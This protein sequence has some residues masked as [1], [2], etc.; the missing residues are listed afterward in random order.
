MKNYKFNCLF[1]FLLFFTFIYCSS[2][3][4]QYSYLVDA[5]AKIKDRALELN[6][7]T[8]TSGGSIYGAYLQNGSSISLTYPFE[9]GNDYKII[10]Y[11]DE[12]VQDLDLYLLTID[13]D[14][15]TKDVTTDNTPELDYTPPY[16]GS[17]TIKIL[18]YQSSA[19]SF[20]LIAILVREYDY[21]NKKELFRQAAYGISL[22]SG[23]LNEADLIFTSGF[24]LFGSY[25][26]SS[27]SD[28]FDNFSVETSGDY[29]YFASCSD[30]GEDTDVII[31]DKNSGE[32][33][34]KDQTTNK[35]AATSCSLSSYK[36]Y[37]LEY[38]N[39]RSDGGA[40]V[41]SAIMK[42]Q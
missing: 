31:H 32:I 42:S 12:D 38:K 19:P 26:S 15:I 8:F 28:F 5:L 37:K 4:A 25:L 36:T 13:G 33:I 11:A 16:S 20:C 23:V 9:Y 6:N 14:E 35:Y 21:G 3:Q 10:G 34:C 18:N 22:M 29:T 40:F 2:I 39:Y 41:I 30:N 24:C 27:S 17:R 1:C 7:Y